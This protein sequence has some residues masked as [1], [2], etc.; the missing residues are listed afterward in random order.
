MVEEYEHA[1]QIKENPSD[2]EEKNLTP[3]VPFKDF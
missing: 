3:T 1:Y 2:D